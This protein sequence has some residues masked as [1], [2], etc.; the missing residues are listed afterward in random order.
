[1]EPHTETIIFMNMKGCPPCYSTSS[2]LSY[3]I[4]LWI[5]WW[6]FTPWLWFW[7][8]SPSH[9][10]SATFNPNDRFPYAFSRD[11]STFFDMVFICFYDG[12]HGRYGHGQLILRWTV[13]LLPPLQSDFVQLPTQHPLQPAERPQQTISERNF[14]SLSVIVIYFFPWLVYTVCFYHHIDHINSI[15]NTQQRLWSQSKT[16]RTSMNK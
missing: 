15:M 12:W 8:Q 10:K 2:Y 6:I 14:L 7:C 4:C 3:S 9:M 13:R 16:Y 5:L 11:L 1:M